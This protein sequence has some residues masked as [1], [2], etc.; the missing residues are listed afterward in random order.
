MACFYSKCYYQTVE[1]GLLAEYYDLFYKNKSYDEEVSFLVS[2]IGGRKTILDAGCGTGSHLKL[3]KDLGYAVEGFDLS[4][5]MLAIAKQKVLADL[6]QGSILDFR[7]SKKYDVVISMFAVFNHLKN[8]D[9]F[10][11]GLLNLLRLVNKGGLLVID[12]HNPSKSGEKE[13]KLGNLT[14]IMKWDYNPVK[15]QE[16][17]SIKYVVGGKEYNDS[18]VFKIYKL[19][20]LRRLLDKHDLVYKFYENYSFRPASGS[21]KNIQLVVEKLKK[22]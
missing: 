21:S 19:R 17:T 20:T 8:Y 10:E 18:H 4:E 14:R 11:K 13:D 9:E 16:T 7:S 22:I 1:Y 3:L 15:N 6:Y 12:L 2:L 5:H